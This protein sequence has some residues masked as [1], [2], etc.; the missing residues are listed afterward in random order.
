MVLSVT[1]VKSCWKLTTGHKSPKSWLQ[2]LWLIKVWAKLL[3]MMGFW[4][5]KSEIRGLWVTNQKLEVLEWHKIG[6]LWV[7]AHKRR[8]HWVR[9]GLKMWISLVAHGA[10]HSI[11]CP[12]FPLPDSHPPGL[13]WNLYFFWYQMKA[14]IF[15]II[16]PKYQLWI[17]Y[18]FALIAENAPISGIPILIFLS[19]F[20]TASPQCHILIFASGEKTRSNLEVKFYKMCLGVTVYQLRVKIHESK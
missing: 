12:P 2:L 6:G 19:I 18:T 14:H 7:A 8:G 3:K 9:A 4:V 10:Y 16:T 11:E 15:L 20:I 1:V 13:N 5:T 17:H